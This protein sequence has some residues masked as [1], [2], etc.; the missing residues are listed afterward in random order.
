MA[1]SNGGK[2]VSKRNSVFKFVLL[3]ALSG[4]V[5]FAQNHPSPPDPATMAR[6]RVSFLTTMLSLSATQQQQATTILTN[7]ATSEQPLHQQM[8]T[9]HESLKA[10]VQK[11]D[12]ASID[13]IAAS[14]GNLTSQSIAI[15][16]KAKAALYS[17][18]NP[19]QQAKFDQLQKRGPGHRHGGPG[20]PPPGGVL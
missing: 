1:L 9:A 10:A 12:A 14:I 2:P 16:A 8:R 5:L 7:A 13:Q 6:D 18:M 11:N 4:A 3:G 19:D 17:L 15:H 20:G